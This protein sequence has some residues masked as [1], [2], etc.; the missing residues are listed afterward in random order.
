[1]K[2][3][4]SGRFENAVALQQPDRHVGEIGEVAGVAD[5]PDAVEIV[6]KLRLVLP[7]RHQ[8]LVLDILLPED[9][10]EPCALRAAADG[11]GELPVLVERR[12]EIDQVNAFRIDAT[13]NVE[14]V[15]AEDRP[16]PDV[17]FLSDCRTVPPSV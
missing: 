17:R 11:G 4:R 16:I 10:A 6:E 15:V 13:Q 14:V 3:N 1:M 9:V 8:P 12:I 5:A 7:D 2:V